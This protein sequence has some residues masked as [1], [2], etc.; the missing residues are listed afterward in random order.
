RC[1]HRRSDGRHLVLVD[2]RHRRRRLVGLA[3]L[4][5]SAGR[6]GRSRAPRR[7]FPRCPAPIARAVD[8]TRD[9]GATMRVLVAH[10]FYQQPG[11]EDQVFRSEL[12]LLQSHGHDPVAFEMHNDDVATM[13][14]LS[15]AAST[16]WNRASS[17][18][19]AD[20]VR[21]NNIDIVHFHNTFPL[22]SPAA[23]YGAHSAGAAVVQ[24]LHNFRFLCAGANFFREG[25]VCE[26]CLGKS[27]PL[28]G[29]IHKCYRDNRAA[30]AATVAMLSVHRAMG[31]YASAV[32]AYITPTNFAREK[33]IAGG[34]PADR[35]VVKPNFVEPDPGVRA[36]G[37]NYAIFVGRLSHEKGL[38]V[39]LDAWRDR[40]LP[41]LKIVGDGP[42]ADQVRQAAAGNASIEW[43]G[44]R[45][46]SEVFDLIGQS[47]V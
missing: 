43:L 28:A 25:K 37:G 40:S 22:M 23:Y 24:T 44:R 11:G 9:T 26:K 13:G 47:A 27:I 19:I 6:R 18:K 2:L 5:A 41:P 12:A 15:L 8:A 30:S 38:D 1:V 31:T 3:L 20:A 35:I 36:G 39:L 42:L 7:G 14:M 16:V 33:F 21:A 29:V 10:N 45:S 32:D 34:I 17:R 4:P 46:T